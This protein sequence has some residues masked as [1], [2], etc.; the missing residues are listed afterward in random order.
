MISKTGENLNILI[1]TES[2]DEWQSFA[3]WYS[4]YVNMPES[5]V[6]IYCQRNKEVPFSYFQWTKRLKIPCLKSNP[7]SEEGPFFLNWLHALNVIKNNNNLKDPFLIIN[8]FV[9]AIDCL[10]E[11][12][13]D[14]VNKSKYLIEEN[15]WFIHNIDVREKI[16]E[17]FLEEKKIEIN[18]N[19]ICFEAK[20]TQ[21]INPLVSYKKGCGRWI[22]TA[23]GCP[24]SNAGGLVTSEM[25]ANETRIINLWRKMVPLYQVIK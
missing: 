1:M 16:N 12:I 19:N 11:N 24:F 7:F 3:C 10:N 15:V 23:K 8:P 18:S 5:N 25:T 6:I 21:T 17:Y 20:E 4:F 13:L 14:I 9:L 22:N 2:G